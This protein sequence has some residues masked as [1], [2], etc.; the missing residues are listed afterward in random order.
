MPSHES[1][2]SKADDI[3]A[4]LKRAFDS[5]TEAAM[6]DRLVALLDRLRAEESAPDDDASGTGSAPE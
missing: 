6:P 1:R 3:D 4:H 5:L 2:K